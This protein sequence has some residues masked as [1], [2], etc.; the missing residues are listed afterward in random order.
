[1][2]TLLITSALV[3]SMT[4]AAN[5]ADTRGST[6]LAGGPLFATTEEDLDCEYINFGTTN[7]TPL[8]QQLFA[9]GSTT[10][11]ATSFGCANGTAVAPNQT[12]YIYPT[13]FLNTNLSYSCNVTFS[14]PATNVRGT[15]ILYDSSYNILS[16]VNLR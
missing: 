1:M 16:A 6:V 14:T 2:K 3:L 5:A 12:C 11:I 10:E 13:D 7:I 4:A 9:N 15:F 8:T